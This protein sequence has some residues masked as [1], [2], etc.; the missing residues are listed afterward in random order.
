MAH[1]NIGSRQIALETPRPPSRMDMLGAA[2]KLGL[3]KKAMQLGSK[4]A[5][6]NPGMTARGMSLAMRGTPRW[7]WESWTDVIRPSF[8]MRRRRRV[9]LPWEVGLLLP[10]DRRGSSLPWQNGRMSMPWQQRRRTNNGWMLL[11]GMAIGG[12]LMYF[13]DLE[14]GNRRRK[15]AVQRGGRIARR[16][17][18]AT[19]R[20]ATRISSDIAG[21]RQM[22]QRGGPSEPLDDATLAHKVE[23]VLF[24]DPGIPKGRLNVNAEH[25]VVVIRGELDRSDEISEIEERVRRIE[26]VHEVRSMMHLAGT[27]AP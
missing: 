14:Q 4:A 18:R 11:A 22:L 13:L 16:S 21:R 19:G 25:G 17:M 7:P 3:T 5:L 2:T 12:A 1:F 24:R 27:P 10:W 15:E 23:S 9:A 20:M 26:G 8:S 6:A